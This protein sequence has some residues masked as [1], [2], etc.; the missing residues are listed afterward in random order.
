[1]SLVRGNAKFTGPKEVT[2]NGEK[3][4]AEHILIATGGHPKMDH[5]IPGMLE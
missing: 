3:Y 4:T 5:N 2:I 1:M